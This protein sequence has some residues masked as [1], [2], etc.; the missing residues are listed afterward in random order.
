[1]GPEQLV[2]RHRQGWERLERLVAGSRLRPAD[3]L[4]LAALYRRATADLARCQ[5]DWPDEP[6][7]QY[8][9]DLVARGHG[10]LYRQGTNALRR[11]LGFYASTLP[12]TY[13]ACWPFLAA[14]ALVMFG[15]AALGFWAVWV[16]PPLAAAFVGPEQMAAVQ[17]HQLWTDIPL[18]IR[19]LAAGSI[20]THN[21]MVAVLAFVLGI[22]L[23]LPTLAVLAVNGLSLGA[24]FAYVT[25]NGLGP[26]LLDFVIAHGTIELSV[27]VAAGACGLMMGWSLVQPG[28]FRRRDALV[29]AGRRC[30]VLIVGLG[31]LLVV[32]GA[33]EGNLS[34][35][36]A[37]FWLK[38]A[39]G[40]GAA[41]V[42]YGWLLAAGR[43]RAG[44]R[45]SMPVRR[46]RTTAVGGGLGG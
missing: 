46:P 11:L 26:A 9:N 3:A 8:L 12:R 19:P 39:V 2:A 22:A 34:P 15:S 28:R 14:S 25:A 43:S 33:I 13:R 31:P 30:Y 45:G 18:Q 36:Q 7:T 6:V 21:I 16:Q 23:A 29:L 41:I 17:H 20:L 37:P 27:V 44:D 4:T 38:A 32:A 1:V 24:T 35:S 5:R 10:L 40:V 42:L